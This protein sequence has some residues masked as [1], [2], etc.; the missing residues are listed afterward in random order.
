MQPDALAGRLLELLRE[1]TLAASKLSERAR[2]TLGP[3]FRTGVLREERA[4]RGR[5]VTIAD[6]SALR[7]WIA[8]RYPSGLSVDADDDL[9]PRATSLSH[10][11]HS[12]R[13]RQLEAEPLLLRGFGDAVLTHGPTVT[14]E[15]CVMR[16][17]VTLHLADTTR[18]SGVASA[19]LSEEYTW[20]FSGTFA[21]VENFEVFLHV[22]ELLPALDAALYAAGRLSTRVIDWLTTLDDA[23]ILHMG[24]YDPVGLDEYLRLRQALGPRVTLHIPTDLDDFEDRVR[25]YGRPD[26]LQTSADLLATVRR[27]ADPAVNQVLEILDRHGKALEQGALLI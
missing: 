18:A 1:G 11:G 23:Q 4:G 19:L 7:T 6:E 26:L 9:P 13:G 21:I 14:A 17:G 20:H 24:D 16:P 8:A 2:V 12:K 10:V 27:R 22:D 15:P 5:R 3:L 25:R